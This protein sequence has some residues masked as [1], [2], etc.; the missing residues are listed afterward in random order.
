MGRF[1]VV[2]LNWN[3]RLA[4]AQTPPEPA[5]CPTGME[6]SRRDKC[7]PGGEAGQS[8]LWTAAWLVP[9][10]SPKAHYERLRGDW[11]VQA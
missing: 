10:L 1:V 2:I 11:L 3:A 9:P 5:F 6:V 4:L 7:C 8:K